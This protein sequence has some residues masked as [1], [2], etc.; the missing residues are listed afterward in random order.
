MKL[1]KRGIP[2]RINVHLNYISVAI[3]F[4]SSFFR[5]F[6]TPMSYFKQNTKHSTASLEESMLTK[7]VIFCLFSK[8]NVV[9]GFVD[10]GCDLYFPN[11]AKIAG[12]K[13][14]CVL[15]TFSN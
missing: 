10:I 4:L 3:F 13:E 14:A 11:G 6:L 12:C 5:L 7:A 9:K 15:G 1:L 2:E 8:I